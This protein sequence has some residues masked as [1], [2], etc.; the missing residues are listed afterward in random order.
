MTP[1][2]RAAMQ[3]A[4]E[5]MEYETSSHKSYNRKPLVSSLDAI[6]A[7]REALEQPVSQE[8]VRDSFIRERQ[9]LEQE[10]CELR[11]LQQA[12][13]APQPV[14]RSELKDAFQEGFNR[15]ADLYAPQPTIRENLTVQEPVAIVTGYYGGRLTVTPFNLASTLPTGMALYAAPQP[16]MNLNCK[17]VQK[18][19]AASWGYVQ[20]VKDEVELADDEIAKEMQKLGYGHTPTNDE[21]KFARAIIAAYREKNK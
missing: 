15:A 8:P 1:K 18:R 19:L 17:S 2:E 16:D 12:Y 10:W 13:T 14:C 20:T 6:I 9:Q 3:Q 7:L 21:L 5:A 11:K 4:L